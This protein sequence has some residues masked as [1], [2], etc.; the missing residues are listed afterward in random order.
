VLRSQAERRTVVA[1][2]RRGRPPR[3]SFVPDGG[4][5]FVGGSDDLYE[6]QRRARLES[7]ER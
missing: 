7:P 3:W 4:A 6:L 1:G 5:G 2:L